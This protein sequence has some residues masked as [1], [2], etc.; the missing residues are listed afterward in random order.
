[1]KRIWILHQG[2]FDRYL[3]ILQY[4]FSDIAARF[5]NLLRVSKPQSPRTP[6]GIPERLKGAQRKF[7]EEKLI[8]RTIRGEMV[9]SK[10]ELAI[11][12]ILYALEQ[13]GHLTY[14]VEPMLPF[15]DR[16]RKW[17]G[18]GLEGHPGASLFV[19]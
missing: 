2:P 10:N 14:Q 18:A 1:V 4:L 19:R 3:A 15:D 13:A 12:N 16:G 7:L 6:A 8:H 9:S 11:A 5:T 17:E